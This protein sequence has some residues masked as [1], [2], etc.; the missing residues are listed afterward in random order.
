MWTYQTKLLQITAFSVGITILN[1]RIIVKAILNSSL[2]SHVF[3]TPC[4]TKLKF[5]VD[6]AHLYSKRKAKINL[7]SWRHLVSYFENITLYHV[8][9]FLPTKYKD[10]LKWSS[11]KTL[12]SLNTVFCLERKKFRVAEVHEYKETNSINF[13]SSVVSNPL[14]Y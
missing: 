10:D 3:W 5:F 11:N 6:I 9:I 8:Y 4:R 1:Q 12:P 14:W 13:L 2:N 7:F